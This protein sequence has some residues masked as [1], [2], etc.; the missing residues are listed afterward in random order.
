GPCRRLGREGL[1]VVP[2]PGDPEAAVLLAP[3][4]PIGG[5]PG[6]ADAAPAIRGDRA[7][8]IGRARDRHQVPLRL[9]RGARVVQPRIEHRAPAT[10]AVRI[11]VPDV[12][13]TV[14]RYRAP[15]ALA[16]RLRPAGPVPDDV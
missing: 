6:D 5:V 1:A 15:A 4:L 10:L 8:A 9:E 7:A 11:P 13:V 12:L 16:V 3:A 14:R 2:R